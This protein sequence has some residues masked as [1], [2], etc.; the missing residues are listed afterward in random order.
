[1]TTPE[2]AVRDIDSGGLRAQIKQERDR[3]DQAEARAAAAQAA[4]NAAC[5]NLGRP[6]WSDPPPQFVA[7]YH[8]CTRAFQAI[9]LPGGAVVVIS[10]DAIGNRSAG[11]AW[12]HIAR[13][14]S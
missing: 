7:A 2:R 8:S 5:A 12:Q 6:Q 1:M 4:L 10:R 11:E 14:L 3:A 13:N 9:R